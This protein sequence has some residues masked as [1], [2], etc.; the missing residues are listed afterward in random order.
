MDVWES[1]EKQ[2]ATTEGAAAPSSGEAEKDPHKFA[3]PVPR[4]LDGEQEY[5]EKCVKGVAMA[6]GP[7]CPTK[8][9]WNHSTHVKGLVTVM[10]RL[11]QRSD[12]LKITPGK[13]NGGAKAGGEL[14]LEAHPDA[15]ESGASIK[16]K[17]HRGSLFQDVYIETELDHGALQALID[18][19]MLEPQE[20][21]RNEE[22]DVTF[23][24]RNTNIEKVEATK[25]A[26]KA[27]A[28]QKDLE[29]KGQSAAKKKA[30]EERVERSHLKRVSRKDKAKNTSVTGKM[31]TPW[32][33]RDGHGGV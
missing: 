8:L 18:E 31:D 13:I 2:I 1:L 15:A 23:Q 11:C 22:F 10:A 4:A 7:L 28:K 6:M 32:T 5:A 21:A 17:V 33:A 14:K 12:I 20:A 9:V 27:D 26:W 29:L 16:V 25:D 3:L 24:G 30:D 19:C